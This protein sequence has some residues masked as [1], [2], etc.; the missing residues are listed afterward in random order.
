MTNPFEY[1]NKEYFYY[2]RENNNKIPEIIMQYRLV[3]S[4]HCLSCLKLTMTYNVDVTNIFN[5]RS[6]QIP[7]NF[8]DEECNLKD[9]YKFIM[10]EGITPDKLPNWFAIWTNY[11]NCQCHENSRYEETYIPISFKVILK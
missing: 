10:K 7:E 2:E 9:E 5:S 8:I 1:Y 3:T 11:Y 6:L 4:K